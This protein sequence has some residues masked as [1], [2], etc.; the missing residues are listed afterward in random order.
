[1]DI[2][3][4]RWGN[5][6]G[7]RI[8][9]KIAQQLGID[10]NSLVELTIHENVLTITPKDKLSNLDELLVSIPYDFQYSDDIAGFIQGKPLGQELL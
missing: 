10:E 6:L 5:S 1:M 2:Q 7:F 3:I 9:F 8:P 4:K